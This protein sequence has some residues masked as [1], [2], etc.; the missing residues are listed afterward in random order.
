MSYPVLTY[1]RTG[2]EELTEMLDD[3]STRVI[4]VLKVRVVIEQHRAE[5]EEHAGDPSWP[6][7]PVESWDQ[8]I[9][10]F[11]AM[12]I[13][14]ELPGSPEFAAEVVGYCGALASMG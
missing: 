5:N 12:T 11:E 8:S 6:F 14:T 3:E 4:D 9:T 7:H 1:V 2:T 13:E 10:Y